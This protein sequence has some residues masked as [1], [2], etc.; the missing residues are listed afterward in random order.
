M[1]KRNRL[2]LLVAATICD[3]IA[4]ATVPFLAGSRSHPAYGR[5]LARS[6]TPAVART[7]PLPEGMTEI[8]D[9]VVV[10]AQA[11]SYVVF[12]PA[13]PVAPT[14]PA[15]VMLHGVAA[16][17]G[18]ESQRDGFLPLVD[19]GQAVLVYPVGYAESWNAGSCCGGAQTAGIDDVGFITKVIRRVEGEPDVSRTFLAGF[20]NGGRMAYR[21]ACTHRR[22]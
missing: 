19:N 2:L 10:G 17:P 14:V 8:T 18:L 1:S 13:H 11:R 4:L 3:L 9:T 12:Q 6:T 21:V 5:T 22:W 16:W 20:S 15:I 7:T